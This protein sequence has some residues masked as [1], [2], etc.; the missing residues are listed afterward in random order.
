[1]SR[2]CDDLRANTPRIVALWE[3]AVEQEPWILPRQLARPDFVPDLVAAIAA[4]VVCVPPT[5]PSVLALAEAAARHAAGRAAAGAEHARVVLEY[6][7]LRNAIWA[8]FGERR[9]GSAEEELRAILYV[10]VAVSVATRAALLG[11][12]RREFESRGAW[13]AALD[14]LVDELPPLWEL[15]RGRAASSSG[16][17]TDAAAGL[18]AEERGER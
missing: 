10:D 7:F 11:Y 14:R 6:Y 4:A 2:L 15:G 3:R 13:P 18:A 16:A 1:M 9:P 8:Y 5:R 12:Y 17:T